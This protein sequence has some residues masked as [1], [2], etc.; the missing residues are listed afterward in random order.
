MS[1]IAAI[2]RKDG[3]IKE[4]LPL[5][6][7]DDFCLSNLLTDSD[8]YETQMK[9][10]LESNSFESLTDI[11][12]QSLVIHNDYAF[13]EEELEYRKSIGEELPKEYK[14]THLQFNYE[15]E[16]FEYRDDLKNHES[17][18]KVDDV[19]SAVSKLLKMMEF[20]KKKEVH[21]PWNGLYLDDNINDLKLLLENLTKGQTDS[22]ADEVLLVFKYN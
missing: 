15:S 8:K 7:Y 2:L 5:N 14:A 4:P 17:W 13:A 16:K 9:E 22:G 3:I 10:H 11:E 1:T 6:L 20:E 18:S 12:H 21:T 19:K